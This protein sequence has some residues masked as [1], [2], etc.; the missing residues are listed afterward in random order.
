[1]KKLGFYMLTLYIDDFDC[2][3]C[4]SAD[5]FTNLSYYCN[6]IRHRIF[7]T[8]RDKKYRHIIFYDNGLIYPNV[9]YIYELNMYSRIDFSKTFPDLKTIGRFN[10]DGN[11]HI[12]SFGGVESIT[13]FNHMTDMLSPEKRE[14]LG[15]NIICEMIGVRMYRF[16]TPKGSWD[17]SVMVFN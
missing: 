16:T 11:Y 10:F 6:N 15:I 13:W 9:I 7:L 1:L 5:I 2:E 12:D 14:K 8:Y 17:I 3:G 4:T